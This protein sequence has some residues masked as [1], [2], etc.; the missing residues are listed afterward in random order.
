MPELP[1]VETVRRGLAPVLEG[2][3]ISCVEQRRPDL[4]FP[5]PE[6]LAARLEGQ[7]IVS[8]DRRAKYLVA[9]LSSG[10]A[11]VMHL[12]MTG[13]FTIT[14]PSPGPGEARLR[15]D[16]ELDGEKVGARGLATRSAPVDPAERPLTR[17]ARRE[18]GTAASPP[19]ERRDALAAFVHE[20]GGEAKHDHVVLHLGSG[21]RVTYNDARRFG[22]MLLIAEA[23][24]AAHALFDG[25]GPEPLGAEFD[26][27]GLAARALGRRT[28]LKAFLMD[29]RTVAG[30]GNIYVCEALHRAG[31]SP[32]RSAGTLARASGR[33]PERASGMPT[34]HAVRLVPAIREVLEAAIKAGGSTLR[35]YR[36]ADG[37]LGY[38]QHQFAV[39]GR[40]GEPC[41]T[42]GCDGTVR[43]IVQAGRSTFHCPRC[44]R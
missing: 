35:D 8:L 34:A 22:F 28:D 32:E 15:L 17:R 29:Q 9:R 23:E 24:L 41:V 43:R 14:S 38:F 18:R 12:G 2:A 39:Y 16:G 21:A 13:R 1:E 19:G 31:L 40:E 7:R 44:Q 4:R 27:A 37:A 6:R 5:F 26:A 42:P 10:E 20:T 3:T 25:L 30:L 11:L 36:H 33:A